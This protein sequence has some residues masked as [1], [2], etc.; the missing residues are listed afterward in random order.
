[1]AATPIENQLANAMQRAQGAAARFGELTGGNPGVFIAS[2]V[3]PD[4]R[5]KGIHYPMSSIAVA[6]WGL[7]TEPEKKL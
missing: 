5:I 3:N 2:A 7:A 4:F 1:M 6:E